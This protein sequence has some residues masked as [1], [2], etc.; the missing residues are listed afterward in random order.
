MGFKNK[1]PQK[2]LKNQAFFIHKINFLK[3]IRTSIFFNLEEN[4]KLLYIF[5]SKFVFRFDFS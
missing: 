2:T 4:S 5:G 1:L 3:K